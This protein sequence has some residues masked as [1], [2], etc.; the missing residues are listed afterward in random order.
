MI[1]V[2][3]NILVHAHRNDSPWHESA[4]TVV[5]ALAEGQSA[6][7]IPWPCVHE[8]LSVV[9]N[10]KIMQPPTPMRLAI[11]QVEAWAESGKLIF[12]AESAAHLTAFKRLALAGQVRGA[13]IHDARIAA[14]CLQHGVR[15]VWT[16]DRDFSLFPDLKTRSP[17]V[18]RKR[19]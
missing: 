15:E 19:D 13:R 10:V 16:A 11:D 12:L 2:D 5:A 9:S 14:I 3:T 6:W 4:R 18:A 1:A 7:A 8:F 17:L